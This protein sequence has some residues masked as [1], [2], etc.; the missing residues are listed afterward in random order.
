MKK[1]TTLLLLL[2]SVISFAQYG[3]PNNKCDMIIPDLWIG[4]FVD[5]DTA[6]VLAKNP[7]VKYR[8]TNGDTAVRITYECIVLNRA[9]QDKSGINDFVIP[10]SSAGNYDSVTKSWN[11]KFMLS[12][13]M[14]YANGAQYDT[15]RK[16]SYNMEPGE[17]LITHFDPTWG[18]G[19]DWSKVRYYG[20]DTMN[21]PAS[22][23]DMY[24]NSMSV[25]KTKINGKT[26]GLPGSYYLVI[27]FNPEKVIPETDYTNNTVILPFRILADGMTAV[28][29][30]SIHPPTVKS[31]NAND[32]ANYLPYSG[33]YG[34]GLNPGYYGDRWSTQQIIDLGKN[35]GS[36]T[37]RMKLTD[38]FLTQWGVDILKPDY[39]HLQDIGATDITAFIGEPHVSHRWDTS[40]YNG[41]DSITKTF[42]GLY[43][44]VWLSQSV[45]NPA[46]TFAKH[47]YDVATK[48]P[49]VKFWEIINEIDY[50]WS[51]GGWLGDNEPPTPGS[52]FDHDPVAEELVNFRAPIPYYVRMLR[53]AYEVIKTVQPNDYIC[54]GGIGNR[55]FLAALLRNTDNP[56]GGKVTADYPYTAGAYFDV[57]SFHTYP[58]FLLKKWSND[59]GG[60]FI[61]NRHSDAAIAAHMKV[62]GWMDSILNVNGYN[63]VKYPKKHFIVT[64]TGMSRV[65]DNDNYGSNEGQ[66]NY[67]MKLHVKT[68]IDGRIK[69]NY[70]FQTGDKPGVDHWD[71]F[72]CHYYFGDKTKATI[73]DQGIGMQTTSELLYDRV[74]DSAATKALQLKS[75]IDGGAFRGSEG[76]MYVLWAKTSQ[77]LKEV[78]GDTFKFPGVDPGRY[79]VTIKKWN[80]SRNGSVT[81]NT[82]TIVAVN[83]TPQFYQ[84]VPIVI[85]PVQLVTFIAQKSDNSVLLKWETSVEDNVLRFEIERSRNVDKWE[86]IAKINPM[87]AGFPYSAL[88]LMPLPVN[89]YRLKIIDRDGKVTYSEI[90]KVNMNRSGKVE[91]FNTVGQR[92]GVYDNEQEAKAAIKKGFYILRYIDSSSEYFL[93]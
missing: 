89:Y 86:T 79:N 25:P 64:E 48:Y 26:V 85:L 37:W 20:A 2:I 13:K 17:Q 56:D 23:G 63:G 15:I 35:I 27:T 71:L 78:A 29:D 88:D 80:W 59:N 9:A 72:G 33:K 60:G 24:V 4:K 16:Q 70:W 54:T 10:R 90:R 73:T 31:F 21:L 41:Y 66:K 84:L 50:T 82:S 8:I 39:Q 58:E 51:S 45:I 61:Y 28:I 67:Q 1:L 14:F 77:D 76:L 81:T 6:G 36:H 91:V 11:F 49:I 57:L 40:F 22:T 83:E 74:F 47:V 92:V 43:E 44:P 30:T 93:K 42:R 69:Q 53:I 65:M 75:T 55:S 52:W 87:G 32:F 19:F 12:L 62:K 5:R 38:D 46:N 18:W 68:L 3:I 34:Y 7:V